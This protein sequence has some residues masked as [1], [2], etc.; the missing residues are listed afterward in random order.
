[1]RLLHKRS[2]QQP[3]LYIKK[4]FHR[5]GGMCVEKKSADKEKKKNAV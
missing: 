5:T 4:D 3:H 2:M 1:M